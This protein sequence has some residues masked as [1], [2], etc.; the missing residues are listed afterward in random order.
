MRVGGWVCVCQLWSD[1]EV[2]GGARGVGCGGM[3]T[4]GRLPAGAHGSPQ[5][6]ASA[7]QSPCVG[8][9]ESLMH[10]RLTSTRRAVTPAHTTPQPSHALS[11]GRGGLPLPPP[12]PQLLQRWPGACEAAQ[13]WW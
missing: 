10:P 7:V 6:W 4:L 5:L 11:S 8:K 2:R 13:W 3:G 9:R 12:L 1:L